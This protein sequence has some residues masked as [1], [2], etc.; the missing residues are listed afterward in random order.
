MLL[1]PVVVV[2]KIPVAVAAAD[3]VFV[4]VSR[5]T[6]L[7]RRRYSSPFVSACSVALIYARRQKARSR[8]ERV[9]STTGIHLFSIETQVK[10]TAE[11]NWCF[12]LKM[13]FLLLKLAARHKN[14]YQKHGR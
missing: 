1:A 7:C 5:F 10:T 2:I 4:K 12:F 14:T 13:L 6:K 3:A 9:M 11:E 8:A